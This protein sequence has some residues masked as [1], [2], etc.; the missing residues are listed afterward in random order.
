M[1]RKELRRRREQQAQRRDA[2]PARGRGEDDD[3]QSGWS[4]GAVGTG[5]DC[6]H[7][8]AAGR[9]GGDGGGEGGGGS[10]LSGARRTQPENDGSQGALSRGALIARGNCPPGAGQWSKEPPGGGAGASPAGERI[11]VRLVKW[12]CPPSAGKGL[13]VIGGGEAQ[14]RRGS[15]REKPGQRAHQRNELGK[16][17]EAEASRGKS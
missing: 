11:A 8:P 17:A 3:S 9:G 16:E 2:D 10:R 7:A 5:D 1:T 13:L 15:V 12:R 6:R 4:S 14:G